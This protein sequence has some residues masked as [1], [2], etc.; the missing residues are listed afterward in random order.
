[1]AYRCKLAALAVSASLVVNPVLS[2]DQILTGVWSGN[3][4][5]FDEKTEKSYPMTVTLSGAT[6]VSEY[7]TLSCGGRWT[8]IGEALGHVI[9]SE[10]ITHGRFD[11]KRVGGCIDGVV[12]L[13]RDADALTLGWYI[14][15][16]GQPSAAT[17]ILKPATQK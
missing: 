16:S 15:F 17:A 11:E 1:M 9:Y 3:M 10:T 2:D 5:Q 4:R 6:G 12:I 14:T 13:K 7:P 8:K